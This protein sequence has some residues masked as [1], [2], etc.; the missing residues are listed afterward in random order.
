M[1]S[2]II[3]LA[4]VIWVVWKFGQKKSS[5]LLNK[6][7]DTPLDILKR[8]FANGEITE[9]EYDEKKLFLDEVGTNNKSNVKYKNNET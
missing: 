5:F 2:W 4:I 8:R 6:K 9:K 3:L 1:Y 7:K